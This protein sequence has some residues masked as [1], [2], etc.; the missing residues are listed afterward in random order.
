MGASFVCVG[1][2]STHGKPPIYHKSD[3]LFSHKV[4]SSTYHHWRKSN[5]IGKCMQSGVNSGYST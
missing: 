2:S 1:Y 4:V 3:I 5:T